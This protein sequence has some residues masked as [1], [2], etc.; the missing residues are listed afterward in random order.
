MGLCRDTHFSKTGSFILVIRNEKFDLHYE[1]NT[2]K[3][4]TLGNCCVA[5]VV[6]AGGCIALP[7]LPI[8]VPVVATCASI[9]RRLRKKKWERFVN[10]PITRG[11]QFAIMEDGFTHM[12]FTLI[13]NCSSTNDYM[14]VYG[15]RLNSDVEGF[16]LISK[17]IDI[18]NTHADLVVLSKSLS[19]YEIYEIIKKYDFAGRLMNPYKF[20]TTTLSEVCVKTCTSGTLPWETSGHISVC[21]TFLADTAR[22]IVK[23]IFMTYFEIHVAACIIQKRYKHYA[24]ESKIHALCQYSSV[25]IHVAEYILQIAKSP[26]LLHPFG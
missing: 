24:H 2:W 12:I 9:K 21:D 15:Y 10:N 23:E 11:T 14:V 20:T 5:S 7:L 8:I 13:H 3:M 1:L 19:S 16:F 26:S 6:C 18:G 4:S 17:D 22:K 25:P